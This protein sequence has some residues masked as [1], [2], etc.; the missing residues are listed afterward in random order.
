MKPILFNTE[1]VRAILNG[2]KTV[3]RRV[4]KP[5]PVFSQHYEH[6]GK[7]L[8]DG[9]VSVWCYANHV[10]PDCYCE[11]DWL[12]QFAPYRPGD[13]LYMR[14]TW[15]I[16]GF[17][18]ESNEMFVEYKADGANSNIVLPEEKFQKYYEGMSEAEPDWHPS[19]HMPREAARIF[20][21]V[22]DV[23]VEKLQEITEIDIQREGII[24]R[25]SKTDF[26]EFV[27]E[28]AFALLW[29]STIKTDDLPLYGWEASPWVWVISFERVEKNEALQ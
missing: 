6:K 29:D 19:I 18:P 14:E 24:K 8:Y 7:E 3:T 11:I 12:K 10:A 2:R 9:E 17:N 5:Q 13:I 26:E 27:A 28:K 22:T 20:L 23:R 25:P 1:M 21:R 4:V 15:G 16:A